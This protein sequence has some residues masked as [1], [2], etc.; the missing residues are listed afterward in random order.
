MYISLDMYIYEYISLN[1]PSRLHCSAINIQ[2]KHVLRAC[3]Q[4]QKFRQQF[5]NVLMTPRGERNYYRVYPPFVVRGLSYRTY[6][7][8][9]M[10]G[11]V[12]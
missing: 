9:C 6:R 8:P 4:C 1:S 11:N 5:G 10:R 2:V 3:H 12:N 7:S